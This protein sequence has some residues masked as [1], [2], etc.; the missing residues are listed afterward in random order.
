[1]TPADEITTAATRLRELA[2]AASTGRNGEPTTTWAV[3]YR[4]N[5]FT[6]EE[7]RDHGCRLIATDTADENGR[8]AT[9]LF[10]GPSG[11]YGGRGP[12]PSMQPRH[13]EYI[14]AMD[15]TV[16]LAVADWLT[17][18]ARRVSCASSEAGQEIVGRRALAVARAI[19]VGGQQ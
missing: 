1:M 15:P 11:G 8:G 10:H 5:E 6:R 14:A 2:T 19:N 18:E 4:I 7:D 9:Q 17:G 16:G 3:R 13:G 12:G